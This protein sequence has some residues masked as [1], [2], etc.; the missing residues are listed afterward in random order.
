[1]KHIS[2]T[3][4]GLVQGVSFRYYAKE[5][6]EELD[7]CGWVRNESD[8]SVHIEV[9]GEEENLKEFIAWCHQGSP[10]AQPKK[11]DC[12]FSTSLKNFNDFEIKF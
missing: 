8:N 12:S 1:M 5:K 4:Y 9:E 11:V 7:I 3:I 10:S 2:I 6:A